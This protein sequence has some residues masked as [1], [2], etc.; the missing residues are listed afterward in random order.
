[1]D[2]VVQRGCGFGCDEGGEG[3]MASLRD[4]KRSA[5]CRAATQDYPPSETRA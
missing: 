4:G 1:M 5:R 2:S 3:A